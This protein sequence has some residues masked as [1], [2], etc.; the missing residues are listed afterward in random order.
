MSNQVLAGYR[1]LDLTDPLGYGCG[2][3]LASMG[4]EVVKV[5]PPGGDPWRQLPHAR[6]PH[7][8]LY[9][10]VNN[11][12]KKS[13]T[14]DITRDEGRAVLRRLVGESDVLLESFRPGYLDELSLGFRDVSAINP[15]L[16]MVSISPFGQDGP[17]SPF[18]GSDLVA[19]A[20]SGV[21]KGTGYPDR[22]PVVEP[23]SA[24][25]FDACAAA[26][27]GISFALLERAASG[28]GQHIDVSA[29]E[30]AAARNTVCLINWQFDRTPHKRTGDLFSN[31]SMPP[32]RFVW[33][34]VDGFICRALDGR[35]GGGPS[36]NP[37]L[38]SWM[39]AE[40]FDNPLKK[41][42][43]S[44]ATLISLDSTLRDEIDAAVE[45]FFR[46]RTV[47]ET[48]SALERYR[49]GGTLV[50]KPGDAANDPHLQ[51]RE[52][53]GEANYDSSRNLRFPRYVVDC[54]GTDPPAAMTAPRIG[55]H[56]HALLTELLGMSEADVRQLAHEGIV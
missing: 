4:A 3:I 35:L 12:G 52:F 21:L 9:W 40:G 49:I 55:Q 29:Q 18:R 50:R 6:A 42:D 43:W 31:G 14:L 38:S 44:T 27:T 17:Y 7:R 39:D 51:A 16:I 56:T 8:E 37:G 45:A 32:R 46:T 34:L 48:E 19:S 10:H 47:A 33:E 36:A 11:T 53:F 13:L 1:V 24:C 20:L 5:E 28:R 22:A 54:R 2:R 41:V 26:F 23:G 15:G 25:A 30:V